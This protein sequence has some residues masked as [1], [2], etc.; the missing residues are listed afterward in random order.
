MDVFYF[1]FFFWRRQDV[2]LCHKMFLV[3]GR[4]WFISSSI[5]ISL[6]FSTLGVGFQKKCNQRDNMG[7]GCCCCCWL[8]FR[9]GEGRFVGLISTR[10]WKVMYWDLCLINLSGRKKIINWTNNN[11][12]NAFCVLDWKTKVEDMMIEVVCGLALNGVFSKVKSIKISCGK[13]QNIILCA[14]CVFVSTIMFGMRI[15]V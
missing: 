5:Y 12:N 4:V 7:V 3:E 10:S 8:C 13:G 1:W 6:V 14:N 9:E 2:L 11:Y 15:L